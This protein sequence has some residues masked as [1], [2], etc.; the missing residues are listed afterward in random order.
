MKVRDPQ[1]PLTSRDLARVVGVSQSAVS[2]AFTPGASISPALRQRILSAADTL[3]YSP[4]AIASTLSRQKSNIV[5]IVVSEMRNPFFAALFERLSRKLQTHQRQSLIFNVTPGSDMKQQLAALRQ[6]NVD[7]VVII[8]A[9][10]LSGAA[11][12]WAAEGRSA[13]L[14]NRTIADADLATVCCNNVEGA[15]AIADH[16]YKQ[17]Y[18]RVA[19]VAG[20][21]HT[22]TNIDR[23]HGFI[24][25]AAELGMVLTANLVAG[26]YSY[27]AG[28]EMAIEIANATETDAVFFANDLLAIGGMDAFRD[29]LGLAVPD[30]IGLAGFDDIEMAGWSHYALTTIRQPI[31]AIV[32]RTV[33]LL[34]EQDGE[35]SAST[36]AT[37]IPGE[38]IVRR[39]T[40]RGQAV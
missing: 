40:A 34:L 21:P 30:Q 10:A 16:F 1:R 7:A 5:G 36:P 8:S 14:I 9:T 17:G 33:A 32:Q 24:S 18:R 15:R 27:E 2:R 3:G 31:E 23:R 29:R 35:G 6:Y 12:A 38:L 20:L 37:I 22:T 4:N 11:L 13:V 19:Y 28:Y 26:E 25:R 39:S